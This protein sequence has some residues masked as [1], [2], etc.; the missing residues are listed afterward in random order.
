VDIPE[1]RTYYPWAR[2]WWEDGC[3][4]SMTLVLERAGSPDRTFVVQSGTHKCW[5][6]LEVT[7]ADGIDLAAGECRLVAKN[8]EDGARLSAVLFATKRY[9]LFKPETPEGD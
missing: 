3:G 2:V 1:S 9:G 8:R 7:G 6:W 4:D 5:H